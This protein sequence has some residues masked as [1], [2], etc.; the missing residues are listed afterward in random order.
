MIFL[1]VSD[2]HCTWTSNKIKDF[3]SES[4]GTHLARALRLEVLLDEPEKMF[5]VHARGRVDVRVDLPHVVKVSV[6]DGLLRRQ[7][8][9]FMEKFPTLIHSVPDIWST[10]GP[11]K[12]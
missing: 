9:V 8:P 3:L 5:L 2:M 7:L 11:A 12:S 10:L 4:T 6:R 1:V